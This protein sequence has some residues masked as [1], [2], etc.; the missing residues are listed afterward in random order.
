[1]S[2][3]PRLL[4]MPQSLIYSAVQEVENRVPSAQEVE[5]DSDDHVHTMDKDGATAL[6]SQQSSGHTSY[7]V[8]THM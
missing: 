2:P 6:T 3:T 8:P 5:E 7:I 1:M 4:N